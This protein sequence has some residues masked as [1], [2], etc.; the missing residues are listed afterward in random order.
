MWPAVPMLVE[1]KMMG[2]AYGM[3]NAGN[4]LGLALYP[5]AFGAINSPNTPEAYGKSIL[6]LGVLALLGMGSCIMAWVLNIRQGKLLDN[7]EGPEEPANYQN[8]I[9]ENLLDKK[10]D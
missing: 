6:L 1:K 5:F 7:V 10:K 4:N 9:K 3:I 2:V 8:E